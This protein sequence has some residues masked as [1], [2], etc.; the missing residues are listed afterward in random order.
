[1]NYQIITQKNI[2]ILT[3]AGDISKEDRDS[4]ALTVKELLSAQSETVII[5]FKNVA[6]IEVAVHR[7]LT[8]LQHEVR[9]KKKLSVIGLNSQ[10]KN[11]LTEKG[12][13]R[14]HE[15][16]QELHDILD[17]LNKAV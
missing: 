11:Y 16:R 10:L 4:I 1:M 5:Y 12:V 7:D 2:S 14:S 17:S 6:S 3:L 8:M 15:F 9:Q 13:I